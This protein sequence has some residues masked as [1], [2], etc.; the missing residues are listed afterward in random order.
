M[1]RLCRILV[2]AAGF[3]LITYSHAQTQPSAVDHLGVAA[4]LIR[5][6]NYRRAMQ[7][8][9]KVDLS[10]KQLDRARYY[11][12]LGLVQLRDSQY[13]QALLSFTQALSEG[14]D[15]TA[16]YAY[17]AQGHFALG[18]YEETLEAIDQLKNLNQFPDI[19]G[20]K[21]RSHWYL[22]QTKEAFDVLEKGISLF[23][24]KKEFLH[25][26][27]VYLLELE[28]N[29]EAAD[30]SRHYISLLESNDAESYISI[31]QALLRSGEKAEAAHIMEIARLLFPQH[32]RVR[33]GLAQVYAENDR[34]LTAA[35]IV[36]EAALF[37]PS[38][39]VQASELYRRGGRLFRA[40]YLNTQVAD[41]KE[42]T[43]QRFNIFLDQ[44]KYEN[45][46]ALEQRLQ[47]YGSF[48]NEVYVYAMAYVLFQLQKYDQCIKYL[49]SIT[50]S[51]LFREATQ[52]RQ[53]IEIM[54]KESVQFFYGSGQ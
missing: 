14:Q 45:A 48:S 22:G 6:G 26:K 35:Q 11:T 39:Y 37:D 49:N 47:K 10:D 2:V 30:Q 40:M 5:D 44:R 33:L 29:Q 7:T 17:I 53:A 36:E 41:Q 51:S 8:L 54:R 28:L 27:I 32:Q 19:Y 20:M 52:L 13:E 21:S 42:K 23:P 25:Q 9:E 3:F 1:N 38:L 18:H 15:D 24:R 34:F 31:S 50:Q 16:L 12:L 43:E 4:V 46:Y